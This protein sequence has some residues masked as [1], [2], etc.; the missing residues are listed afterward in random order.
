MQTF[1]DSIYYVVFNLTIALLAPLKNDSFIFWPFILSS[2]FIGLMAH[3]YWRNVETKNKS[4]IFDQRFLSKKIWWHR[5]ARSDYVLYFVNALILPIFFGF[6]LLNQD[7]LMI[8]FDRLV[9]VER[10]S[11]DISNHQ[12]VIW[13]IG[14][15]VI[16]FIAYDFGRFVA[17]SL[18]HDVPFLWEFHKVHH[19]AEVLTPIT[20]YRAHPIDLLIMAWGGVLASGLATW[21]FIYL[22]GGKV[23]VVLFLGLNMLIA[24]SNLV[25]NL[26]HT[27]IW[28]TYGPLFGK[29]F[30]SP[31][32]HQLH[33]SNEERHIGCN[34]G[35]DLAIWD[36]LYGTLYVP[37]GPKEKFEIGLGGNEGKN[38]QKIHQM[39]FNPFRQIIKKTYQIFCDK[40]D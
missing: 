1:Y 26:R 15:T 32:H 13:Q 6:F 37:S 8:W 35:F 31:A 18:L 20:S 25:G 14:F 39:L 33:H 17:H 2:I 22:A 34:R 28:I 24:F 19:S 12:G 9:G 4:L 5:S 29:W 7:E 40:N 27:H 11:P 36:R 10:S 3:F 21:C 38:W 16:F 23:N 30:I